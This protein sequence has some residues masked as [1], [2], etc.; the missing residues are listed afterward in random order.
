MNFEAFVSDITTNGWK[1]H[2]AEVYENGVLTHSFGDTTENVH[3]LY[4]IT[5]SVLSAAVGITVFFV[6]VLLQ[7]NGGNP[8]GLYPPGRSYAKNPEFQGTIGNID[9]AVGYLC[10]AAGLFLTEIVSMIPGLIHHSG[11][12][13]QRPMLQLS[14]LRRSF[15]NSDRNPLTTNHY[16]LTTNH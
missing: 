16:P 14:K 1:V 11:Q 15:G 6:I 13:P 9:M 10:L 8:L 4:S 12:N 5:K 3:E 7:R 2:G